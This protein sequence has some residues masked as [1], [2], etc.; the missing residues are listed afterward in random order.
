MLYVVVLL[1]FYLLI[2]IQD[3]FLSSVVIPA[4]LIF[5]LYLVRH[6]TKLSLAL[7][8]MILLFSIFSSSLEK[9]RLDIPISID[10]VTALYGEV[11]TEP[12]RKKNRYS[13]Y[14]IML[15][16]VVNKRG[17]FFSSLGKVYIIAPDLGV[18]LGDKIYVKGVMNDE[19][20]LSSEG[21]VIK[22][23][24]LSRVRRKINSFFLK[25]LPPGDE[26]NMVSLLLTG[27]TLDGGSTLQ[28]NVRS[29]GL[30]HL[31]S[32]SGMHLGFI[33]AIVFPLL[34][35]FLS[36]KKAVGAKNI[37]LFTFVYTAGFRPSLMRS[38]IFV[39]LI[40]LFGLECSFILSLVAL[41]KIFPF[42]L[43]E[44]ATILSFTSLA[45][46]LLFSF[47]QESIK[48]SNI[49]LV[50]S[51]GSSVITSVAATL[52]SAPVVFNIFGS[53]QPYS[54]LF[55]I[56]GMPLITVLFVMVIVRFIIPKSDL[57][58]GVII[59]IIKQSGY[60]GEY[61][62]LT[63]SF[64]LYYPMLGVFLFSVG[65]ISTIGRRRR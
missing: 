22:R 21:S 15:E 13:G 28:D 63:E 36:R 24:N 55:S 52:S 40:P 16:S 48:K 4:L 51:I 8:F 35:L 1:F 47:Q 2:F 38:M 59:E 23:N 10:E 14:N 56:V 44:V 61:I 20:F 62:P 6:K 32:L 64:S 54:F 33:S 42:Y 57:I 39:I 12:N 49:P 50:S 5:L 45:G 37:I 26:G 65:I 31:L 17:D 29:L 43:D 46:I 30:S 3:V 11:V 60:I 25:S 7:L 58:I 19:Y 9:T 53:W 41:I 27:T 18:T 34:R